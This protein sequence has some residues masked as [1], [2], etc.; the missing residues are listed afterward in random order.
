MLLLCVEGYHV[1]VAVLVHH[2]EGYCVIVLLSYS[3]TALC[4]MLL[5]YCIMWSVTVLLH[6]IKC[7]SILQCVE[8]YCVTD[9][10]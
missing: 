4:E 8:C 9:A 6:C 1:I 5:C 7:Y 2:G 10:Q 3:V